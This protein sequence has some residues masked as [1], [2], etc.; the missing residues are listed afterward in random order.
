MGARGVLCCSQSLRLDHGV[1]RFWRNGFRPE[2]IFL[3]HAARTM[4]A[5]REDLLKYRT[6]LA[7][8]SV[9]MT[10]GN[11]LVGCARSNGDSWNCQAIFLSS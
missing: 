7:P 2:R 9:H 8:D 1:A 11:Q 10:G 5:H 4:T 3:I 6:W